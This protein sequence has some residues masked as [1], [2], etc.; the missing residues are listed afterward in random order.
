M[1]LLAI[2]GA[3]DVSEVRLVD[4]YL[5]AHAPDARAV[6][7]PDVAH[8]I[9]L[10]APDELGALLVDFLARIPRWS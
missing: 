6:V 7:M 5:V 3:L 1:P 9:G 4:A 2:S 10:E 8:L